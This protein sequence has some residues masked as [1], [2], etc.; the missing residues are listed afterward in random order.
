MPAPVS[1]CG[2]LLV[3]G[4][5]RH[6][7]LRHLVLRQ[8]LYAVTPYGRLPSL[9][10]SRGA[11]LA[12]GTGDGLV[13]A[14]WRHKAANF[15]HLA[16]RLGV[17]HCFNRPCA[18]HAIA[19]ASSQP[20]HSAAPAGE[21]AAAATLLTPGLQ[22]AFAPRFSPDGRTL[23]FLSLET[24]CAT[25]V[26]CATAALHSLPWQ[27]VPPHSPAATTWRPMHLPIVSA[28]VA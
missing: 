14:V 24:A 4:L 15:P 28:G 18:L 26:H 25:G 19:V 22:S 8:C 1:P 7:R 16:K 2:R 27:W 23:V 11:F 6:V 5:C 10:W 3:R 21:D 20:A 13:F 9:T 12:C 17:V